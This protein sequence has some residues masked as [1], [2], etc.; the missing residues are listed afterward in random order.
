M[1]TGRLV[2]RA[3]ARAGNVVKLSAISSALLHRLISLEA[4][5]PRAEAQKWKPEA[6]KW[7]REAKNWRAET[8][9][10]RAEAQKWRAEA[11]KWQGEGKKSKAE[12]KILVI[13]AHLPV[14]KRLLTKKA[15]LAAPIAIGRRPR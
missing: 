10:W 14:I 12:G 9:N 4:K 11:Q 7:K 8:Q 13:L 3:A 6:K 2:R 5:K 15:G 1:P